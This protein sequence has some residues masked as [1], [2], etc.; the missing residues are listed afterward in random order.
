MS[1]Y[2]LWNFDDKGEDK[3]IKVQFMPEDKVW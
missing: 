2:L 1:M 3:L